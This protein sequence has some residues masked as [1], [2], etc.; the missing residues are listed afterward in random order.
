MLPDLRE[1]IPFLDGSQT[2]PVFP[3]G[4]SNMLHK[5]E[6]GALAE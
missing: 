2:L 3:A 1:S 5:V 4:K 6:Y